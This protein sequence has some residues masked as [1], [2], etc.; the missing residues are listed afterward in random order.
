MC[1]CVCL[2]TV[3]LASCVADCVVGTTLRDR[4]HGHTHLCLD[5]DLYLAWMQLSGKI[6]RFVFLFV[7]DFLILLSRSVCERAELP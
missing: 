3:Q 6:C 1:V 7:T 2:N 4:Q 5:G